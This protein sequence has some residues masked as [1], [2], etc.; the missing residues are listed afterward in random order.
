LLAHFDYSLICLI[1][2]VDVGEDVRPCNGNGEIGT[3]H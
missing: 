3:A 1:G 2:V